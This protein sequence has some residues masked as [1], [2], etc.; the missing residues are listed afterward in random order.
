MIGSFIAVVSI[1]G[2]NLWEILFS[3]QLYPVPGN[4]N[5][6]GNTIIFFIH[7]LYNQLNKYWFKLY[8]CGCCHRYCQMYI[9]FRCGCLNPVR[10]KKSQ[11][12][13]YHIFYDDD[14]RH[15]NYGRHW[16]TVHKKRVCLAGPLMNNWC[17]YQLCIQSD[18]IFKSDD[19]FL[20]LQKGI[21]DIFINCALIPYHLKNKILC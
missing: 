4:N 8:H 10:W 1:I 16:K 5:L 7:I 15:R 12:V 11:I 18:R 2:T 3:D 17:G 21:K 19:V 6:L 13:N 14:W 9:R 20:R